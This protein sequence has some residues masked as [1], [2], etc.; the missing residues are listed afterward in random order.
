MATGT[1]HV[2]HPIVSFALLSVFF[3]AVFFPEPIFRGRG[4][5][6]TGN[7]Y[8]DSLYR[9]DKPKGWE[10]VPLLDESIYWVFLPWNLYSAGR[11][12]SGEIPLWNPYSGTGVPHLANWQ[13]GVFSPLN[14]PL[15]LLPSPRTFD[16]LLIMKVWLASFLTFLYCRSK[17]LT[18][19][20]A[21]VSALSYGFGGAVISSLRLYELNTLIL[22][23]VYFLTLDG[24]ITRPALRTS[25]WAALASALLI[26]SGH[27]ESTLYTFTGGAFYIG[28]S[29]L[30][31]VRSPKTEHV[32]ARTIALFVFSHGMGVLLS[33]VSLIPFLEFFSTGYTYRTGISGEAGPIW[34]YLIRFSGLFLPLPLPLF[35]S[36]YFSYIGIVSLAFALLSLRSFRP[37]APHVSLFLLGAGIV[38]RIPPFSFLSSLPFVNHFSSRYAI[39]LLSFPLAIL[40]GEGMNQWMREKQKSSR[41]L[42]HIGVALLGIQLMAGLCI[43]GFWGDIA[44]LLNPHISLLKTHYLL[45][46]LFSILVILLGIMQRSTARTIVIPLCLADLILAGF[47]FNKT[48]PV[49]DYPDTRALRWLRNAPG[50]FRVMGEEGSNNVPNSGIVPHLSDIRVT[51]PMFLRRYPGYMLAIDPNAMFQIG[52]MIHSLSSPL[53]D[54]LNVKY[55][56]RCRCRVSGLENEDPGISYSSFPGPISWHYPRSLPRHYI[57]RYTDDYLTI[58]ENTRAFPRAFVVHKAVLAATVDD[59]YRF[60]TEG[61]EDLRAAAVLEVADKKERESITG[62]LDTGDRHSLVPRKDHGS[63]S[64]IVRYEPERVTITASLSSPGVLIL[65]DSYYPGWVV[66]I[67]GRRGRIYPADFLLRGVVLPA[68]IHTVTFS[69]QPT[70]F[71]AGASISILSFF[72]SCACLFSRMKHKKF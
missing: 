48:T 6:G 8:N 59:S 36:A 32:G 21:S 11:F 23:P 9:S 24:L 30:F 57:K 41:G 10:F 2:R 7:L 22:A 62:V 39:G 51:D 47:S 43:V 45:S 37:L 1:F 66:D 27:P 63:Q 64:E 15:Y 35:P 68:G 46:V 28:A 34:A 31:A 14:L 67:D 3:C 72:F 61:R 70:S 69:Y 60:I 71:K 29:I 52:V 18:F 4:I 38:F 40:A 54:L 20:P 49:F 33:S 12:R 19:L 44:P 42:T 56:L 25:L 13:S 55:V 53:L 26:L 16:L 50:I 17:G 5:S 65:G 58:Y